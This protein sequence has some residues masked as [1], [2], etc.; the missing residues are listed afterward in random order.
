M[1]LNCSDVESTCGNYKASKPH[2]F[3]MSDNHHENAAP[4]CFL[5]LPRELRDMIYECALVDTK[6][7]NLTSWNDDHEPRVRFSYRKGG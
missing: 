6:A 1:R 4:T 5:N 3:T 2:P 7:I